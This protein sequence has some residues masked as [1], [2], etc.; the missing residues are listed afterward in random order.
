MDNSRESSLEG[1]PVKAAQF[2][3]VKVGYMHFLLFKGRK[4]L[5]QHDSSILCLK[6]VS[7][8]L[9]NWTPFPAVPVLL[10]LL[11]RTGSVMSSPD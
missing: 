9:M 7:L 3:L 4:K 6:C 10:V 11:Q 5:V 1:T 8:M 2:F